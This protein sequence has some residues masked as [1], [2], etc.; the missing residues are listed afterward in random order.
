LFFLQNKEIGTLK[1]LIKFF[2][3]FNINDYLNND[4]LSEL[5]KLIKIDLR[6]KDTEIKNQDIELFLNLVRQSPKFS[7]QIYELFLRQNN[8]NRYI[9]SYY[10]FIDNFFSLLTLNT[11]GIILLKINY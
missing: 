1:T 7:V 3:L 11:L 6:K 8:K 4:I 2:Y 5:E 10:K 9:E